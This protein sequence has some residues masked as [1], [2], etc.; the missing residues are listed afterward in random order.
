MKTIT[1]R[2]QYGFSELDEIIEC[3]GGKAVREMTIEYKEKPKC[4]NSY[5]L[6]VLQAARMYGD[7]NDTS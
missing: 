6:E 4:R 7:E 5:I 3:L 1:I 2:S